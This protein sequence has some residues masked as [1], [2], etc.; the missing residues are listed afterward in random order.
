MIRW[1]LSRNLGNPKGLLIKRAVERNIAVQQS[2]ADEAPDAGFPHAVEAG[3]GE[4][5]D[6]PWVTWVFI[7][8]QDPLTGEPRA[9]LSLPD[10][11]CLV[12]SQGHVTI[13]GWVERIFIESFSTGPGKGRMGDVEDGGPTE[14]VVERRV[15]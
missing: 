11:L 1:R 6:Q 14:V 9:E 4:G 5:E 12:G 2:L 13:T 15:G 7:Y 8:T 10:E 3:H